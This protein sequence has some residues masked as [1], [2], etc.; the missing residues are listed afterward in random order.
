M[1]KVLIVLHLEV[2]DPIDADHTLHASLRAIDPPKIPHFAGT[3]NVVVEPHSNALAEWLEA[4]D[5]D[6]TIGGPL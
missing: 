3:M 2:P 6:V 1:S 4:D 5:E